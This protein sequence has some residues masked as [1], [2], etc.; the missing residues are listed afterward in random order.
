VRRNCLK[1]G[2]CLNTAGLGNV[3]PK[4]GTSSRAVTLT[5]YL[6]NNNKISHNRSLR[7]LHTNLIIETLKFHIPNVGS[8]GFDHLDDDV[9]V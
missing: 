8:V 2:P 6:N 4:K 7:N 3:G 1:S 9:G 5:L